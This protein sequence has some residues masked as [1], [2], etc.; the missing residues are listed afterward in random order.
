MRERKLIQ[1]RRPLER[2]KRPGSF[3]VERLDHLAARSVD[4]FH[5]AS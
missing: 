3:R 5:V 4:P 1:R 2:R